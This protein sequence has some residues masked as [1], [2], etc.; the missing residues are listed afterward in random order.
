MIHRRLPHLDQLHLLHLLPELLLQFLD[1]TSL[2]QRH[3]LL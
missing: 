1:P 3:N 2:L